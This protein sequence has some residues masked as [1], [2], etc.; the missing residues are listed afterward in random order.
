[1]MR[2]GKNI[3]IIIVISIIIFLILC[4]IV[5]NI[6]V[7][8]LIKDIEMIPLP[9]KTYIVEKLS[10][11]G[12]LNGNGNGM[13]YFGAVLLNSELSLEELEQYYKPFRETPWEYVVEIQNSQEIKAIE[14]GHAL[15]ESDVFK[16]HYYIVYSWGKGISP[17]QYFDLRGH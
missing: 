9:K 6:T 5:N 7:S 16:D 4:P 11:A 15:F 17:F 10:Q 2:K 14:H 1:M 13:Q 8:N 3:F 12:K